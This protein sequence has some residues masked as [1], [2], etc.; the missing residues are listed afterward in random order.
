MASQRT[1][2][3]IV[4][5]ARIPEV[6]KA[7][8]G[9]GWWTLEHR[10]GWMVHLFVKPRGKARAVV[11]LVVVGRYVP[12]GDAGWLA[13]TVEHAVGPYSAGNHW[14]GAHCWAV[15]EAGAVVPYLRAAV[16]WL[17]THGVGRVGAQP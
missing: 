10:D 12:E 8:R 7:Q 11:D 3:A 15:V 9:P 5:S 6:R 2:D 1:L 13:T 17:A 14:R 4:R 16:G